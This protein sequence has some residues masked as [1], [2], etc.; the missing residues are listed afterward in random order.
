[1]TTVS[2]ESLG[3][4][5]EELQDRVVE[6]LVSQILS[7][8]AYDED[9]EER[10]QS[11]RFKKKLEERLQKHITETINSLAEK[12]VLPN[13]TAYIENLTLQ[14]T[15]K[16]G[17]AQGQK[18]TFIEY[19]VQRAEAYIQEEVSYDGKTQREDS[20]NWRKN[21]TRI[22]F[23]IE[24]HLQYHM[25]RAMAQAL[26][27]ANDS[28]AGGIEKAVRISLEQILNGIKVAVQVPKS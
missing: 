2:L 20:Y 3:I 9:G 14:N 19:L 27:T 6:L 22:N 4:T 5:Q 16:W 28:I 12:N 10:Y 23:L 26:K 7:S 18:I 15:N 1:M 25:E 8:K 17:E 24:K 21:T 11:S 13:V